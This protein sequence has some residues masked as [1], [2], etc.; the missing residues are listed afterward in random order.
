MNNVKRYGAGLA[1]YH[2]L[3]IRLTHNTVF[4]CSGSNIVRLHASSDVIND[5]HD[6]IHMV[7]MVNNS[8]GSLVTF[9]GNYVLT[10]W[11]FIGNEVASIAPLTAWTKSLKLIDCV[12][13][14][15]LTGDYLESTNHRI[16]ED[17]GTHTFYHFQTFL[18]KGAATEPFTRVHV[19]SQ[20][21]IC[22]RKL[23]YIHVSILSYI[24]CF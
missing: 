7:N 12:S 17:C 20:Y 24:V 19:N 18:C 1:I 6:N 23:M 21:C 10:N 8:H 4:G 5:V 16:I 15:Q 13:D 3:S 22:T 2:V 14:R 11:I 9:R